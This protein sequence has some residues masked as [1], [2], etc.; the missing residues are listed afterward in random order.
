MIVDKI[1]QNTFYLKSLQAKSE[2]Q[3][4]NEEEIK[5]LAIYL[6]E[7]QMFNSQHHYLINNIA[8]NIPLENLSAFFENIYF[9]YNQETHI[10]IDKILNN[11]VYFESI[12]DYKKWFEESSVLHYMVNVDKKIRLI[13]DY[14]V[15]LNIKNREGY[16]L[17][18]CIVPPSEFY[19][20]INPNNYIEFIL[21]HKKDIDFLLEGSLEQNVIE[22]TIKILNRTMKKFESRHCLDLF[23]VMLE[24]LSDEKLIIHESFLYKNSNFYFM[25]S[26]MK[27]DVLQ[28]DKTGENIEDIHSIFL[29]YCVTSRFIDPKDFGKIDDFV[30]ELRNYK[31]KKISFQENESLKGLLNKDAQANIKTIKRL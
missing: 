6:S 3:N 20:E 27:F 2:L 31:I 29:N 26:A 15:D 17:S 9:S 21:K 11:P 18:T 30:S 28:L 23:D 22:K 12:K 5:S 10:H 1:K 7:H 24:N 19:V 4:I 16:P 25:Q 8:M 13:E 14:N